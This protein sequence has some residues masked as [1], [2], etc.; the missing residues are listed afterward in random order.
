MSGT[1]HI[2]HFEQTEEEIKLLIQENN[3]HDND[4]A[5]VDNHNGDNDPKA[6]AQVHELRF[7]LQRD[8]NP[9]VDNKQQLNPQPQSPPSDPE[10]LEAPVHVQLHP[11]PNKPENLD[12][13]VDYP[14]IEAAEINILC[15]EPELPELPLGQVQDEDEEATVGTEQ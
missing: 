15:I 3:R 4:P 5:T 7:P 8:P 1:K 6:A 2:D 11:F 14:P 10:L 13:L 12:N 9:P